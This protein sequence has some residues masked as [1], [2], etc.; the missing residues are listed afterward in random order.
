MSASFVH[1][2]LISAASI[3]AKVA[4]DDFMMRVHRIYP[5]Y[6]FASHKGYPTTEHRQA[7]KRHGACPLHRASF[8]PVRGVAQAIKTDADN[9]TASL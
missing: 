3:L 9:A 2:A 4:R 6:N 5:Q 1:L 7:L 8:A